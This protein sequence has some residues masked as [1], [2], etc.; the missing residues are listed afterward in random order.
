MSAHRRPWLERDGEINSAFAAIRRDAIRRIHDPVKH[1]VWSY[2]DLGDLYG[3]P[4][5]WM[6]E[7]AVR[8]EMY[9]ASARLWLQAEWG[10]WWSTT[11][12]ISSGLAFTAD[13]RTGTQWECDRLG[14]EAA[15]SGEYLAAMAK[16]SEV[17]MPAFRKHFRDVEQCA[18]RLGRAGRR[19]LS[20][21][22]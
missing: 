12:C 8:N 4:E 14:Q 19:M 2:Q 6:Y 9:G 21:H 15:R 11:D 22:Q 20:F 7:G 3:S 18:E 17:I 10:L 1:R 13:P 16:Q 5:A